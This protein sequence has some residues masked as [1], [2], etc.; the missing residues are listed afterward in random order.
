MNQKYAVVENGKVTNIIVFD[1]EP[2][3]KDNWIRSDEA[4]IGDE[5]KD[6]KFTTPPPPE[7]P[8]APEPELT[9][10]ELISALITKGVITKDDLKGK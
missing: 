5:Y 7:G 3:P 8:P 9:T 2:Q 1:P 10:A 4:K 6:G